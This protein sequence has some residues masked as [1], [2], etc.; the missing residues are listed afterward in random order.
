MNT[1][2]RMHKTAKLSL[3]LF[4]IVSSIVAA[5]S[6]W[7]FKDR[8]LSIFEISNF[9]GPTT[10]S[11]L[12]NGSLDV[13]PYLRGAR[14]PL[15]SLAVAFF[16]TIVGDHFFQV[17][18]LKVAIS[19]VAVWGI[20]Y[21]TLARQQL[22][23]GRREWLINGLLFIPLVCSPFLANLVN[24]QVEEAYGFAPIAYC[25]AVLLLPHAGD[26]SGIRRINIAMIVESVAFCASACLVF[27]SKSSFVILAWA[28]V[29]LYC[30]THKQTT[31]RAI[32]ISGLVLCCLGWANFQNN[33][34]GKFTLGTSLD[35]FNF[36]K[37]NN[38]KFLDRYPPEPGTN[39]DIY[40][41]ELAAG[42]HFESEWDESSFYKDLAKKYIF[43]NPTA[44]IKA[45]AVK[46]N[47][48]LL[49][50][51]KYGSTASSG[52]RSIYETIGILLFRLVFV[53]SLLVIMIAIFVKRFRAIRPVSLMFLTI[54]AS[55]VAPYLAGF[56]YT[57]HTS[58]LLFPCCLFL[59]ATLPKLLQTKPVAEEK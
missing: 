55:T 42:R 56:A 58:V 41:N 34:A 27:L 28:F 24:L 43:E 44:T 25:V 4:V 50:F 49:S 32:V 6:A 15:A 53:A 26:Q 35:G 21:L 7:T 20:I 12:N 59:Y 23:T 33:H 2:T 57:R 17:V 29:L 52:I 8:N 13:T 22:T 16:Y 54:G 36:Y 40:D 19:L 18:L 39:L 37:G 51:Q 45:I 46:F 10:L 14:M 30:V 3:M 31:L 5:G 11:F 9:V 38:A 47:A 1:F 48:S